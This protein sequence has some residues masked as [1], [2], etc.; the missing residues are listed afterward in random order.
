MSNQ[1]KVEHEEETIKE[2]LIEQGIQGIEVCAQCKFF[3]DLENVTTAAP[4][5]PGSSAIVTHSAGA[6]GPGVGRC[7][8]L[9][10]YVRK[11]DAAC[12]DGRLRDQPTNLDRTIEMKNIE[13]EAKTIELERNIT[14]L[15]NQV[16]LEKQNT[17]LEG[18]GK[19]TAMQE[20]LAKDEDIKRLQKDKAELQS[21]T[22]RLST[23][24]EA[25]CLEAKKL[26][27]SND[28]LKVEVD[29]LK[30]DVSLNKGIITRLNDENRELRKQVAKLQEDLKRATTKAN[31]ES[32]TRAEAIQRAIDTEN[33][34]AEIQRENALLVER[35]STKSQ[36]IYEGTV[37]RSDSAKREMSLQKEVVTWRKKNS[38]LVEEYR[39][40]KQLYNA[41]K[42]R[43]K[44]RVNVK[45]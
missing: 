30:E 36:E 42:D 19:I 8:V 11:A 34:A 25:E 12:I 45:T 17:R 44:I 7:T 29:S 16:L 40:L 24:L 28:K 26:G 38:E 41:L 33:S 22:S 3:E 39:E 10:E 1:E 21:K 2:T 32:A 4:A 37:K 5:A 14:D 20:S 35:L 13:L 27:N 6:I 15:E 43:K 9:N 23:Q 18:Q 31:D